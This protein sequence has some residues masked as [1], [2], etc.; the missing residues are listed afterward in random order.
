MLFSSQW[1]LVSTLTISAENVADREGLYITLSILQSQ[2][3]Q[4]DIRSARSIG[5]LRSIER[6]PGAE[7]LASSGVGIREETHL[8]MNFKRK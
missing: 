5:S 2:G 4:T 3:K 7:M 1:S 8:E 6:G